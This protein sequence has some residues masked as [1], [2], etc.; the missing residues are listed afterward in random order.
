[1]AK[2]TDLGKIFAGIEK[3][4]HRQTA[5]ALTATAKSAKEAV[6]REMQR[7]FDRPTPFTLRSVFWKGASVDQGRMYAQ[8][9]LKGDRAHKGS[10][11][12]DYLLPQVE[13][14]TRVPKKFEQMLQRANIL[15]RGMAAV[16]GRDAKRDAYGNMS[17]GQL[18]QVLS[19]LQTFQ[20]TGAGSDK[21]MTPRRRAQLAR[22]KTS[23]KT[24]KVTKGFEYFLLR[25]ARQG[26]LP[27]V[28]QKVRYGD[29]VVPRIILV[30]VRA[31]NYRQRLPF[32]SVVDGVVARE[33]AGHFR[34]AGST[35]RTAVAA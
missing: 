3:Q 21:N 34:A 5:K 16:P 25:E 4:L 28:Y 27:G 26:F 35:G 33:F 30:F 10:K 31:P 11:A 15:P 19:A 2:A 1:M 22:D 8:V 7:V 12:T 6:V 9:Y 29:R 23:R 18:V 13:G 14:G 24:G 32:R 20:D 17:R